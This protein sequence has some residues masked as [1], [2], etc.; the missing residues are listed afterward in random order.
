[1]QTSRLQHLWPDKVASKPL[2][3]PVLIALAALFLFCL[4]L[5]QTPLEFSGVQHPATALTLLLTV[6]LI[7]LGGWEA[8]RQR[9]FRY[10]TVTVWLAI[11]ALFALLPSF[12]LH[13]DLHTAIWQGCNVLLALLLFCTLQQF[14]FN[15]MQRQDLLLLPLLSGW[16]L[17]LPVL[18]PTLTDTYASYLSGITVHGEALSI[19]LLTALS[20]SAYLLARTKVYKRN[21]VPLHA[22]LLLTPV[23]TIPAL[24]ALRSPWLIAAMLVVTILIQPFLFRFCQKRHHGLWNLAVLAGFI[25]AW[26]FNWLP[27][28][29]LS[30][31]RYSEHEQ[32]VLAQTWALLTQS[33]F[34]GVGLG[35]L[36]KAQLL[37]GLEQQQGLSPIVPYPSWL[38]ANL[39]QGGIA[40]WAGFGVLLSL[41]TRRLMEAPGGTR[42]MLLAI[43]LPSLLGMALTA[44][45]EINPAFGVL[46]VIL[47]YWLDNLSAHY[48]RIPLRHTRGI[49]L[50]ANGVLAVTAFIVLSSIYL[51]EQA[52]STYQIKDIKLVQYQTHPWWRDY[53]SQEAGMRA[54]HD[55]LESHDKRA[56]EHYLR[57]QIYRL[58]THPNPEGYQSLIELA[59]LTGHGSIAKQLKEEAA[60]LFPAREFKLDFTKMQPSRTGVH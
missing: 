21:W 26:H 57:A 10:T 36:I 2:V 1:M 48:R 22:V 3:K 8:A 46:F 52:L 9:R 51:G 39:T 45:M 55:A 29:A 37:F 18:L 35:Q 44:Y 41:V 27:Q 28:A 12:Y 43:L 14:S 5:N 47:V 38:L 54:F 19:A 6:T 15:H 20:L 56:Q 24:A 32:A 25:L 50:A 17:A 59:M 11:A 23:F 31:A 42:L 4:P 49:K 40:Y 34:E 30:A 53:F 58:G 7:C 13:A 60:L 33:Q 16:L